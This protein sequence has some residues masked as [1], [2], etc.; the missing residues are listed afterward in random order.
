MVLFLV[1]DILYTYTVVNTVFFIC[2]PYERNLFLPA[3]VKSPNLLPLLL[4][5]STPKKCV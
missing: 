5:L 2:S 3:K 4:L 1:T